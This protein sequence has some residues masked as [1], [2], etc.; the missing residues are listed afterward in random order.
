MSTNNLR[1]PTGTH[2][3]MTCTIIWCD[4]ASGVGLR[5]VWWCYD[6]DDENGDNG[7][8]FDDLSDNDNN[9]ADNGADLAVD[10]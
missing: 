6:D 4:D 10:R 3:C 9:D 7:D 8:C 5:E 1:A 2:T